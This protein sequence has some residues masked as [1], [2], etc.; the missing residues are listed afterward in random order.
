MPLSF[1]GS[2]TLYTTLT[3]NDTSSN[4]SFGT[5]MM[6]EGQKIM[7]GETAWPF[8]ESQVVIPTVASQ[9]FYKLAADTDK[10]ISVTIA[11]GTTIYTPTQARSWQEWNEINSTSGITSD[12]PSYY[13]VYDGTIGI[14]PIP[15]SSSNNITC[16]YQRVTRDIIAADYTTG[17]IVSVAAAGTAVVGTGTTWTAQMA[18]Q[19][20]QITFSNTANTGDGLLYEIASVGSATTLTLVRKYMG[21]A[22]AAGTA[23]Y[24][25]NDCYILPERYQIGPV[26]YAAS[27]YWRK[28]N[29]AARA[30]R[31]S[32]QFES[33]MEQMK[34]DLGRKTVDR[35][36]SGDDIDDQPLRNPNNF[37]WI[38]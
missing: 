5:T 38:S 10:I 18:G 2:R 17:S 6:N 4:L 30:D 1:T 35:V 31:F 12:A 34:S 29:D 14:W 32:A 3:G 9:Q 19:F 8:M 25:I 15:S 33:L 36:I 21:T 28:E 26:L 24:S 11:I 27:E 37:L 20:L 22:I 23:P 7:L 13:F 16:S